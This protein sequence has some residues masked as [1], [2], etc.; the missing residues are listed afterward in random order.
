ML[1]L[2]FHKVYC[3]I[4]RPLC[5]FLSIFWNE[6]CYSCGK[7]YPL[8]KYG[9]CETCWK[10]VKIYKNKNNLYWH[11][12]VYDGAIKNVIQNFKYGKKKFYARKLAYFVYDNVKDS[13]PE[14]DLIVPVPLHW[15]KEFSR[16]FNQSGIIAVYLSK[17]F[18]KPVFLN[19]VVKIKNT[20]AQA[21]L[22]GKERKENVSGVFKVRRKELIKGKKVV[23]FDDVFTTGATADEI[24]KELKKEGAKKVIILTIAKTIS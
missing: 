21:G 12:A 5:L 13:F 15:R 7:V 10:D 8:N 1:K 19:A 23:V 11:I 20:Q 17:L 9:F 16:G 14:F 6:K 18:K 2:F 3:K 24:K 4:N 22:S